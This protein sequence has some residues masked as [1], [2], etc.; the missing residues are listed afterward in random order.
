MCSSR[1]CAEKKSHLW[2]FYWSINWQAGYL[3]YIGTEL[4][5]E[6]DLRLDLE[7]NCQTTVADKNGSSHVTETCFNYLFDLKKKNNN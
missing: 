7:R 2:D 4:K 1:K 5:Q 6:M 3:S